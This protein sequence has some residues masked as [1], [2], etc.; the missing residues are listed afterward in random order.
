MKIL[1]LLIVIGFVSTVGLAT[2]DNQEDKTSQDEM[3]RDAAADIE[4]YNAER[5]VSAYSH[6]QNVEVKIP[7]YRM[8]DTLII[9][10]ARLIRKADLTAIL[11]RFFFIAVWS[12]LSSLGIGRSLA[13]EQVNLH[14]LGFIF[15]R[16]LFLVS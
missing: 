14:R 6:W 15:L 7:S 3:L 1:V 16:Y 8:S 4:S 13:F 10:L 9:Q 11:H 5:L 12:S 2:P